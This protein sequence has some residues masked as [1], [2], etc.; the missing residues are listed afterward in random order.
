MVRIEGANGTEGT[1]ISTDFIAILDKGCWSYTR[2]LT[3][4]QLSFPFDSNA[5]PM[6]ASSANCLIAIA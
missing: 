1:F 6:Q 5:R 2:S 3:N 4:G